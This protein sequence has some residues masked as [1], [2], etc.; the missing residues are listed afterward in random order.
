MDFRGGNSVYTH[1]SGG[2]SR[3]I[4]IFPGGKLSIYSL[5]S[6]FWGEKWVWGKNEYVTPVLKYT[7]STALETIVLTIVPPMRFTAEEIKYRNEQQ[8]H[9]ILYLLWESKGLH[10]MGYREM[11][12]DCL[13]YW[14]YLSRVIT[15]WNLNR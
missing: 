1:F 7:R 5:Y 11:L 6:F 3:Y 15:Y 13:T 2:K 12:E 14:F 9:L 4:L 8:M 10:C